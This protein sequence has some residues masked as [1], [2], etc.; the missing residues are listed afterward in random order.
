[1]IYLKEGPFTAKNKRRILAII[2]PQYITWLFHIFLELLTK[3]TKKEKISFG[4]G[5]EKTS[6][7]SGHNGMSRK[8][9][10]TLPKLVSTGE[11]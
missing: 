5:K 3:V 2:L 7:V 6:F 8:C 10:K 9:Q 1:L 11:I 4:F